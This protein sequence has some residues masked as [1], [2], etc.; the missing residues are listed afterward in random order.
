MRARQ[1]AATRTRAGNF[2]CGKRTTNWADR[3]RDGTP[4]KKEKKQGREKKRKWE[5]RAGNEK[6]HTY[7]T[8]LDA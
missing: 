6:K 5:I 7:G 1:A 2:V 8:Y 3:T 4:E